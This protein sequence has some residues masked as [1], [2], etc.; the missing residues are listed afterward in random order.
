MGAVAHQLRGLEGGELGIRK[1]DGCGGVRPV[2]YLQDVEPAAAG[3]APGSEYAVEIL[4]LHE[5]IC[6][7]QAGDSI[8][9]ESGF[10]P[11][12]IA[13]RGSMCLMGNPQ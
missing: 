5:L 3:Q 2:D 12:P 10:W 6:V 13:F 4:H 1:D 9:N 7:R 11:L 8:D